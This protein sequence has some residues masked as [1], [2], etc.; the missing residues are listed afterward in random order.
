MKYT[1]IVTIYNKENYLLR[2]LE[3]V[4]NQSYKNYKVLV[5]DD[6]STDNSKNVI[7]K[8]LKKWQFKYVYKKNS[9][10]ADTRNYAVSL[11]DTPYFLFVDG[12]DYID[13]N[14]LKEAEKYH[15]Y[16]VLSFAAK[17]VNS[18]LKIIE[19]IAKFDFCGDGEEYLRELILFDTLFSVPWGYIYN[20][21]YFKENHFVYPYGKIMEDFYLTPFILADASKVIS[22]KYAGYYYVMNDNSITNNQKNY[23]LIAQTYL[24][25]VPKITQ[26]LKKKD[27]EDITKLLYENFVKGTL[28]CFY[29]ELPENMRKDYAEDL[30]K[31]EITI[32]YSS[33]IKIFIKKI[34]MAK[35]CKKVSVF[36]LRKKH[37]WDKKRNYYIKVK[38]NS[39]ANSL[40]QYQSMYEDG[41]LS[42][43]LYC[44]IRPFLKKIG[45]YQVSSK[46]Y[47]KYLKKFLVKMM[48]KQK[49]SILVKQAST[50]Q[51]YFGH[52][53]AY[54]GDTHF[55]EQLAFVL[56][57]DNPIFCEDIADIP[58][59]R[60][61]I[62]TGNKGHKLKK[63]IKE[64]AFL[65]YVNYID[66]KPIYKIMNNADYYYNYEFYKHN[67]KVRKK[68]YYHLFI[69]KHI[70]NVKLLPS[71]MFIKTVNSKPYDM[72]IKENCLINWVGD[73]WLSCS[74][75]VPLGSLNNENYKTYD[76]Y[77]TRIIQLSALNHTYCFYNPKSWQYGYSKVSKLIPNYKN[78]SYEINQLIVALDYPEHLKNKKQMIIQKLKQ[79]KLGESNQLHFDEIVIIINALR[80]DEDD[81]KFLASYK[82]VAIEVVI[83]NSFSEIDFQKLWQKI[84]KY[85]QC[86]FKNTICKINYLLPVYKDNYQ[87]IKKHIQK[88]KKYP[89]NK[90]KLTDS[91]N[92]GLYIKGEYQQ[93]SVVINYKYL[94]YDFYC[95]L[96]DPIFKEPIVD[97]NDFKSYYLNSQKKYRKKDEK[98]QK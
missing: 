27:Y 83:D 92:W 84:T 37:E 77:F 94:I 82:N 2:C 22:I 45:I 98:C 43:I 87:K 93:K 78:T 20:T 90:I 35:I 50:Q 60:K 71:E 53:F 70:K 17:K 86:Y 19:K 85:K 29:T 13:L 74:N 88:I 41:Y 1:I 18:K 24:E 47:Q 63:A 23:Q 6:G 62:I 80:L 67:N 75:E 8:A 72:D 32:D 4:C 26:E 30:A 46:F 14:L 31:L 15:D 12:D 55:N 79:L 69:I 56:K 58:R 59:D 89:I 54:W 25:Y 48:N 34:G 91:N 9:G 49:K 21:N 44:K 39:N 42:Y 5:I 73:I 52:N 65:K 68:T 81:F 95:L 57:D 97:W 11:V 10:I 76:N 33:R 61:L 36:L 28:K 40:F 51:D 38:R 16:D 96:K 3:S 64:L 66:I 7:K